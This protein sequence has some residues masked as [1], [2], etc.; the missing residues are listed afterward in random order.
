MNTEAD[1]C[2]CYA[3]LGGSEYYPTNLVTVCPY[4]RDAPG[5]VRK[6]ATMLAEAKYMYGPN[7]PKRMEADDLLKKA[8]AYR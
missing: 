7:H 6:L 1:K 3:T 4:H 8:E 5:L 2:A